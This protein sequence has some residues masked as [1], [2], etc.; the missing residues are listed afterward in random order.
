MVAFQPP[1][2]PWRLDRCLSRVFV[3]VI[4]VVLV[5]AFAT[6][7]SATQTRLDP[8]EITLVEFDEAGWAEISVRLERP[9][10][11]RFDVFSGPEALTEVTVRAIEDDAAAGKVMDAPVMMLGPGRHSLRLMASGPAGAAGGVVQG[12]L[13]ARPPNDAFEPNNVVEQARD[14]DLPF[15]SVIRLANNDWDWFRIDPPRRGVLG[16]QLHA[17][18]AGYDGPEIR[19][20]DA[21]G[22]SLYVSPTT[23]GGWNGMRYVQVSGRPVYVGVTDPGAWLDRQTDGYKSLEIVMIQPLDRMEGQ[24]ITLGLAEDDPALHQLA[25]IG[26]ALGVELRAAN[27]SGAVASELTRVVEG[28]RSARLP[29]W[30]SILAVILVVAAFGLGGW[31]YLRGRRAVTSP[32]PDDM[33]MP[34][35]EDGARGDDTGEDNKPNSEAA[36]D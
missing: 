20:V 3:G 25:Q 15:H 9:A 16:I 5:T 17:W 31:F 13:F 7:P 8:N 30:P 26:E 28:R 29:L 18:R 33:D 32:A 21:D 24:L 2:H 1:L 22:E 34:V 23:S 4:M 19:V 35:S 11:I 14:I 12:R 36:S 27:E 10:Q 6:G